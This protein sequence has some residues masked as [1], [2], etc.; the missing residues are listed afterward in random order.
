MSCG[1]SVYLSISQT[2]WHLRCSVFADHYLLPVNFGKISE[3]SICFWGE[4]YQSTPLAVI[5]PADSIVKD[6]GKVNYFCC[7]V[8][9]GDVTEGGDACHSLFYEDT[10][11]IPSSR[12]RPRFRA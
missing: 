9:E 1:S 10:R 4:V 11:K 5:R 3:E 2:T 8:C 7:A 12:N 6:I